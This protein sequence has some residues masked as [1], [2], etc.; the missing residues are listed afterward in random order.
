MATRRKRNP[1][2]PAEQGEMRE[3]QYSAAYM[4]ITKILKPAMKRAIK[5]MNKM[6]IPPKHSWR[7]I[8]RVIQESW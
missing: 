5:K 4:K 7:I 3:A 6:H 8:D 2:T 1:K